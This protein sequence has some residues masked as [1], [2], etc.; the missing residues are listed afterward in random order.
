MRSSTWLSCLSLSLAAPL[1]AQERE[2]PAP[3]LNQEMPPPAVFDLELDDAVPLGGT[4]IAGGEVVKGVEPLDYLGFVG[5]RYV[6]PADERVDPLLVGQVQLEPA[7]GRPEATSFGYVLFSR[8]ITTARIAELEG[9]GVRV[10]G[11]HPGYCLKVALPPQRLDDVAALPFV[12][13]I[14]A[15]RPEQKVQ[16]FLAEV[17]QRAPAGAAIDVV[18]DLYESDLCAATTREV[19]AT[20]EQVE[21][22]A[23]PRAVEDQRSAAYRVHSNGWQQAALEAL[24]LEVREYVESGS[25]R[26]FLVRAPAAA[27]EV[28]AALDFVAFVEAL[29]DAQLYHDESTPLIYSDSVRYYANGGTNLV[30]TAGE[31][32]SGIG[33]NHYDIT[34]HMNGLGWDF[35]G[36]AGGPWTD[37]CAHGTHVC[38]TITGNGWVVPGNRGNAPGLGWGGS[39]RFFNGKIFDG[40]TYTASL[41]NVL[42]VFRNGQY[43]G[44]GAFTPRPMVINNSWGSPGYWTGSEY[45]AR[46]IDDEIFW[47]EQMYVFAAGN[48]ANPSTIGLQAGA[49]N[50]SP[51]AASTT[52]ARGPP[53]PATAPRSRARARW[54]TRAGSPT[55]ARRAR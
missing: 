42:S 21:P 29:P 50:A 22:G 18:V 33:Y 40:C 53:S 25:V 52:T 10:L 36:S 32:D 30:V 6:P 12:R 5:G 11:F 47:Q 3:V 49:K 20:A 16:P 1:G 34:T 45:D 2:H 43:D 19:V 35:S 4:R 39:G 8:R 7:D 44:G 9:L 28:L 46:L 13:W 15:P 27:V 17:A 38:G 54:R 51:S 37:T 26:A 48:D 31:I 23:P 41:A 14:G 24:G 55:S